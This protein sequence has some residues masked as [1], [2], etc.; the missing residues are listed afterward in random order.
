LIDRS[1]GA[2][3]ISIGSVDAY[4][5]NPMKILV[6]GFGPYPG[7]AQNPAEIVVRGLAH[8]TATSSPGL[9]PSIA[10]I[11]AAYRSGSQAIVD[12]M[13][14]EHPE[15]LLLFGTRFVDSHSNLMLERFALNYV[16][17]LTADADGETKRNS[18]VVDQGP[19]ALRTTVDVVTLQKRL[20]E[21]GIPATVSNH[22]G[23]YVCNFV[24]YAALHEAWAFK[25]R[26]AVLLT[27][28][29]ISK[30]D[31]TAAPAKTDPWAE[32]TANVGRLVALAAEGDRD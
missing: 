25:R 11:P 6:V 1:L 20:P 21:I 7:V 23:V 29:P 17:S 19:E 8:H 30:D 22:A 14:R 18:R 5:E 26:S 27:H 24:Y 13:R 3:F 28:L 12:L 10:V 15:L 32:M 2:V 9:E 16:D 31:L 4:I